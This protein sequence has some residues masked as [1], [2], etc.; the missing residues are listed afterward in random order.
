MNTK[1][2]MLKGILVY[3]LTFHPRE[4][5]HD[6]TITADQ[7]GAEHADLVVGTGGKAKLLVL[8]WGWCLSLHLVQDWTECTSGSDLLGP[9][10]VCR[11]LVMCCRRI[12]S[13][14][15]FSV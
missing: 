8:P 13:P 10:S 1:K 15:S 14:L 4:Q 9:T 6:R 5:A 12:R 11:Q 2:G 7:C 3:L